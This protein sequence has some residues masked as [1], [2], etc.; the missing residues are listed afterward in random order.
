MTIGIYLLRF[1]GTDK[2]YVGQSIQ[3]ERRYRAHINNLENNEASDKLQNAY[4]L[5]GFPTYE[6]LIECAAQ[7]LNYNENMAI[8][9]FNSVENGFNSFNESNQ[10]YAGGIKSGEDCGSSKYTNA[11]ILQAAKLMCN[12]QLSLKQISEITNIG[13]DNIR[14]IY[15]GRNHSW[16]QQKHPELWNE[17]IS[18]KNKRSKNTYKEAGKLHSELLNAKSKGIIYPK[19][20]GPDGC[21]YTIDNLSKFC[22]EHNVIT[23]NFCKMLHGKRKSCSGFKLAPGEIPYTT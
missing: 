21:M 14:K 7:E 3:I 10:L 12:P 1:T 2:V 16:I 23:T 9:I 19:V 22:T 6:I 5:Y 18:I 13:Y 17:I 15:Q 11:E 8:E 20:I 4:I